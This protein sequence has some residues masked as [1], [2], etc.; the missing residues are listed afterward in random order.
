[1]EHSSSAEMGGKRASEART[2]RPTP[3]G[4]DSHLAEG[5]KDRGYEMVRPDL[6]SD[7]KRWTVMVKTL[8]YSGLSKQFNLSELS[9]FT[10]KLE[11]AIIAFFFFYKANCLERNRNTYIS[12]ELGTRKRSIN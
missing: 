11:R 3:E 1:M 10:R 9:F 6:H 5:P 4:G 2:S 12:L 8:G 7:T